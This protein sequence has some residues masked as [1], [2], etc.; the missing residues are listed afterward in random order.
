[1]K[2]EKKHNQHTH[3]T[4]NAKGHSSSRTKQGKAENGPTQGKDSA[5][6]GH[7]IL[8]CILKDTWVSIQKIIA[9]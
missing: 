8:S 6:N 4:R 2:V 1:M 7:Y 9:M 5:R 3:T